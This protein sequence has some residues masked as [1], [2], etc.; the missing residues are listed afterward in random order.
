MNKEA[1]PYFQ[2]VVPVA[3][4]D[5]TE[6]RGDNGEVTD[7]KAWTASGGEGLI[8][9]MNTSSGEIRTAH[10]ITAKRILDERITPLIERLTAEGAFEGVELPQ[11]EEVKLPPVQVLTQSWLSH[12]AALNADI[13]RSDDVDPGDM[14]TRCGQIVHNFYDTEVYPVLNDLANDERRVFQEFA[15]AGTRIASLA[16]QRNKAMAVQLVVT[17]LAQLGWDASKAMQESLP[18][19]AE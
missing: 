15:H 5:A 11:V 1:G 9:A 12:L 8:A 7:K 19:A 14:I 2:E 3:T 17:I 13:R 18:E 10:R 6:A 16:G 4:L